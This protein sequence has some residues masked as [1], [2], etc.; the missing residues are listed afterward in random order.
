[1][2]ILTFQPKQRKKGGGLL[3]VLAPIPNEATPPSVVFIGWEPM[4]P[5]SRRFS[6][7]SRHAGRMKEKPKSRE[8]ESNVSH[9]LKFAEGEA[10]SVGLMDGWASPQPQLV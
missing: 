6:I 7:R 9:P 1:M 3:I 5:A 2:G 10:A 8:V 4:R